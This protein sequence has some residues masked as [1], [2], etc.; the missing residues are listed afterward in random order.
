[1]KMMCSTSG[2]FPYKKEMSL[3]ALFSL[4]TGWNTD[5]MTGVRAAI[6]DYKM[7]ATC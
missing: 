2:Q 4:P 3:T 1:M 6:L 7:E 5:A